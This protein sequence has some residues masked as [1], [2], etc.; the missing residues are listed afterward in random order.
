VRLGQFFTPRPVVDF[1]YDALELVGAELKRATLID[2]SCG[3][4]QWLL[5]GL[6]RGP[7]LTIGCDCDPAMIEGWRAAG[8]TE[9]P[10]CLLQVANA[11]L[12]GV[13]PEEH[14]DLVVGNPPF[15][16]NLSDAAEHTLRAIAGSYELWRPPGPPR[17]LAH[18]MTSAERTRLRRLPLEVLFLE[19]FVQLCRPEGWIAIILPEGIM[20]NARWLH[21]REWLLD[22]V[23]VKAVVGLPRRTF[24]RH[25][26]TAKTCLLLAQNTPPSEDGRSLPLV[27]LRG[28]T[29]DRPPRRAT[30][31]FKT[32]RNDI[33]GLETRP[34]RSLETASSIVALAEVDECTA[35]CFAALLAAW[36]AGH[37]LTDDLPDGLLPP[38]VMRL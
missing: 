2:P 7:Q 14:F 1:A 35:E 4:G 36:R 18:G 24:H 38:P 12:P 16:T 25:G 34:T 9:H 6:E 17:L 21:V 5:A 28:T 15:G 10:D 31:R 33:V 29:G 30:G 26:T 13:L 27:P 20:A 22:T 37:E 19:R 32:S 11:L 23:T 3:P 8:L